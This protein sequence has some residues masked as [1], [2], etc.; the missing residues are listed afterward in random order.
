MIKSFV[1]SDI[2][3]FKFLRENF[4]NFLNISINLRVSDSEIYEVLRHHFYWCYVFVMTLVVN[5]AG[6]ILLKNIYSYIFRYERKIICGD[7]LQ[8]FFFYF[9][10]SSIF[11]NNWRPARQIDITA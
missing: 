6:A 4:S 9:Q 11:K 7:F 5:G 10:I 8:Y 1:I 2:H 3:H